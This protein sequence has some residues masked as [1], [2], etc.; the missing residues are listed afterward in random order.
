MID[1]SVFILYNVL[2]AIFITLFLVFRKKY[3]RMIGSLAQLM[4]DRGILLNRLDQL[5]LEAS[6][7][8]NDGFIKFL[9][10]SRDAAFKYIEDVQVAIKNYLDAINSNNQESVEIARMELFSH[11]PESSESEEKDGG[12]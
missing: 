2:L 1:L 8:V 11:L 7:E 4:V 5:E 3:I 10:Q 12:S 9:S 6:K